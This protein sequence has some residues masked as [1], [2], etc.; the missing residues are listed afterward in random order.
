MS[1]CATTPRYAG[2]AGNP[3]FVRANN[4]D[5]VWEHAV[6]VLHGHY[7]EIEREN[8]LDGRIETS[9]KTGS[10]WLEPWHRDSVGSENRWESTLQPI[11]RK[12]FVSITPAEGGYFVGVEVLKELEDVQQAAHSEGGATFLDN[13]PLRRDLNAV[14]GQSSPSGWI[15]KGRDPALEALMLSELVGP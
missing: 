10:G 6:D 2:V 3:V 1:G 5:A 8:R 15:P 14:V 11:R 12:A 13:S 4:Q 9:Y 7:F